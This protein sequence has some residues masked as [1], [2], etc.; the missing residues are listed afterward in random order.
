M[1][2]IVPPPTL[3]PVF[4]RAA[5]R[6]AQRGCHRKMSWPVCPPVDSYATTSQKAHIRPEQGCCGSFRN[7][8]RG[9]YSR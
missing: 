5:A 6:P 1:C 3:P 8:G 9:P 2:F 7:R 4:L